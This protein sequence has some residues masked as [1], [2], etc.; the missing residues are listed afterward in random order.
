MWWIVWAV[1]VVAA[2]VVLVLLGLNVW[3]KAKALQAEQARAQAVAEELGARAAALEQAAAEAS[4]I[5]PRV[6]DDPED[7]RA[8]Y[9]AVRASHA[10][11]RAARRARH[12]RL[13]GRWM[14][15]EW[16]GPYDGRDRTTSS[17]TTKD[18]P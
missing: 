16:P 2:L 1:L 9:R 14:R 12:Q 18:L 8:Q 5:R 4:R 15:D 3:V 17:T 6:Q 10:P 11:A 7:L 13:W